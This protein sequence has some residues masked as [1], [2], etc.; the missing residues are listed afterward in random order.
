MSKAC[1]A[2]HYARL[3]SQVF[4]FLKRKAYLRKVIRHSRYRNLEIL[5]EAS[6]KRLAAFTHR[7]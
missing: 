4:Y 2:D 3:V 1:R 7:Q 6:F 5:R